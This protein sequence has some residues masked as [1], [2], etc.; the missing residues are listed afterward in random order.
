VKIRPRIQK[1]QNRLKRRVEKK[2][3]LLKWKREIK[4]VLNQKMLKR[5]L[6]NHSKTN[7]TV[8]KIDYSY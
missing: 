7:K 6:L 8:K 4:K 5:F 2:M 3:D 1:R